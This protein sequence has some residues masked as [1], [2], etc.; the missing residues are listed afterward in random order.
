MLKSLAASL[1]FAYVAHSP[2]LSA[3]LL[4]TV[5]AVVAAEAAYIVR[6]LRRTRKV[7]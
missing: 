6:S 1:T 3:W 5:G 2:A 4:P 7:S